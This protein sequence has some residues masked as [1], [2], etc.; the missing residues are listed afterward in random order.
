MN[1]ERA[2]AAAEKERRRRR[3]EKKQQKRKEQNDELRRKQQI[4]ADKSSELRIAADIKWEELR[5]E[6]AQR[7][8]A[9]RVKAEAA[10]AESLQP[11]VAE[12]VDEPVPEPEVPP[13]EETLLEPPPP[14]LLSV[15]SSWYNCDEPVICEPEPQPDPAPVYQDLLPS[16]IRRAST[17]GSAPSTPPKTVRA[18]PPPVPEAAKLKL[19]KVTKPL[20]TSRYFCPNRCPNP[21]GKVEVRAPVYAMAAPQ[22][23]VQ[24]P[25]AAFMHG[26]GGAAGPAQG[27]AL[28]NSMAAGPP[29]HRHGR[30]ITHRTMPLAPHMRTPLAPHKN[31]HHKRLNRT[32]TL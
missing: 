29:M 16:C 5:R 30:A 17:L 6:G 11:V 13:P 12:L 14:E 31:M 9:A 10:E 25:N 22:M 21:L 15:P 24:Q 1:A 23:V 20:V 7:K 3:D 28:H 4:A 19:P 18:V 8:E 2:A 32:H 26:F 27:N